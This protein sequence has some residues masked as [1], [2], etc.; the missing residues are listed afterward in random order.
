LQDLRLEEEQA[1]AANMHINQK[2]R[3]QIIKES[4]DAEE[5]KFNAKT[6]KSREKS[7]ER[8]QKKAGVRSYKNDVADDDSSEEEKGAWLHWLHLFP[9]HLFLSPSLFRLIFTQ[10]VSYRYNCSDSLC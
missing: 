5:A 3:Y 7:Y 6:L 2:G 9:L 8:A 10:H 1:R 4:L